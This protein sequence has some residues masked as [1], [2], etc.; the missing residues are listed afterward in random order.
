MVNPWVIVDVFSYTTSM[1]QG[2]LSQGSALTIKTTKLGKKGRALREL[3]ERKGTKFEEEY[4]IKSLR[5]IYE[6]GSDY[7]ILVSVF[8]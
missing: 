3:T 7:K 1:Y 8:C 6:E 4:I 2:Y 5:K